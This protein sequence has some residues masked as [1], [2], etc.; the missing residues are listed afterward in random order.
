[1]KTSTCSQVLLARD[2]DQS[3][4]LGKGLTSYSAARQPMEPGVSLL[5]HGVSG[6]VVELCGYGN[7]INPYQAAVFVIAAA[8]DDHVNAVVV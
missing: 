2:E 6:R 4:T 1:M 3:I 7:A 5:T 8:N